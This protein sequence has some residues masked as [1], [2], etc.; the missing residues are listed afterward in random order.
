[1]YRWFWHIKLI[2]VPL[3]IGNWY[4]MACL[5]LEMKYTFLYV[6][7]NNKYISIQEF[8]YVCIILIRWTCGF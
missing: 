7:V 3:N 2:S 1:M 6:V 8:I 4:A 5:H